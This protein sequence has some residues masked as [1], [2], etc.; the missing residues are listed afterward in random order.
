[1]VEFT[2]QSGAKVVINIAPFKDAMA[3]KNA[4]EKELALS[5]K[6][7]NLSLKD[8]EL[9]ALAP[10]VLSIDSS[11]NVAKALFMCLARCTYNGEKIIEQTFE[12]ETAREDYYEIVIACMKANVYPLLKRLI[13]SL[14]NLLSGLKTPAPDS[15]ES[16]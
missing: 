6:S 8:L 7:M 14:T 2:T 3:L 9:G 12:P 13:S 10:L 15:Q 16:K 5:G 1:M 11:E 4:L